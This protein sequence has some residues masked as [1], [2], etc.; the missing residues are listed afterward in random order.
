MKTTIRFLAI[1]AAL[2]SLA[3]WA[4]AYAAEDPIDPTVTAETP[5]VIHEK[6]V[7]KHTDFQFTF[8]VEHSNVRVIWQAGHMEGDT[9]VRDEYKDF[10]L[11]DSTEEGGAQNWTELLKGVDIVLPVNM[12]T[13]AAGGQ[14]TV[15]PAGTTV[16]I[17]G[18][19]I[20]RA[21]IQALRDAGAF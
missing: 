3:M 10:R 6:T 2:A 21:L 12:P 16:R 11:E 19:V 5:V 7:D 1:L 4:S 17:K 8:D 9:F 14:I 18:V 15:L 20:Y 13:Q